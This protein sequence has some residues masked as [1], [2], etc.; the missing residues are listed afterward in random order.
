MTKETQIQNLKFEPKNQILT[1]R[2]TSTEAAKIRQFCIEN[3]IPL[4]RLIRHA[5]SQI[6]PNL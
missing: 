6:I 1:A 3:Q 2:F 5:F 4:S